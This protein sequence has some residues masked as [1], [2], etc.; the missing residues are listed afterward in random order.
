MGFYTFDAYICIKNS[1]IFHK[2]EYLATNFPQKTRKHDGT[3]PI[4]FCVYLLMSVIRLDRHRQ[5]GIM[6]LVIRRHGITGS[7][8]YAKRNTIT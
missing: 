5:V 2:N 8:V 3:H 4:F 1:L 6:G 7:P